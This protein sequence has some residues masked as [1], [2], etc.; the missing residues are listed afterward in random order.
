MKTSCGLLVLR[1]PM[2]LFMLLLGVNKIRG[3]IE[4]FV[5]MAAPSIPSYLPTAIGR[6]YLHAVPVFEVLI[7]ALIILGLFGRLAALIG[8][9]MIFSFTLAVTGIQGTQGLPFQ[10]NVIYLGIMLCLLFA[11]PGCFSLDRI[12]H[13]KRRKR[14]TTGNSESKD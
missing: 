9:L 10:T 3:G 4:S 14:D 13:G 12:F 1:V 2:G 5:Q 7:G 8:F 6:A 11:G